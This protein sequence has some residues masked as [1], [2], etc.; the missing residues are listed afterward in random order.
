MLLLKGIRCL[1]CQRHRAAGDKRLIVQGMARQ[2]FNLMAVVIAGIKVH[3][4]INTGRILT[5]DFLHHAEVFGEFCPV[6]FGQLPQTHNAVADRKLAGSKLLIKFIDHFTLGQPDF[7]Q[8]LLYPGQ[9]QRQHRT[10]PLQPAHQ[11]GHESAA[12][13][14]IGARHIS[15]HDDL[16]G[17]IVFR[18]VLQFIDPEIGQITF[19]LRIRHFN[20]DPA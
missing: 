8:P 19:L 10:V 5:Q 2:L 6:H 14:R 4:G 9:R 3:G 20:T 1:L 16:T 12:T 17:G 11:F 13:R 7:T 15:N 18:A